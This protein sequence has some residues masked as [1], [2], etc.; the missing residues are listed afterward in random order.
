MTVIIGLTGGIASGKSLVSTY[1]AAKGIP[2]IDADQVA[3]EIVAPGEPLLLH[4]QAQFGTAIATTAGLN[5]AALAAVIFN[6]AHQRQTLNNLMHPAIF[7]RMNAQLTTYRQQNE[8]VVFLDVPLLFENNQLDRYDA[9][10]VVSV[11]EA[12]Q[13]ERLMARNQLTKRAAL[14]RIQ[15]QLS[16][17]QKQEQADVIIDNSG[18]K[19]QT[20]AQI[21]HHLQQL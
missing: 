2:V 5:R 16:L 13:L 19:Q 4:L 17:A 18:T 7:E 11:S 12:L 15:A 1:I 10:W 8:A 3:R 20:F 9:I 6:D 21:D 14:Q